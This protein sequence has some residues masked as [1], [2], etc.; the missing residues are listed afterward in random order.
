MDDQRLLR[1]GIIGTVVTAIC[2]FTPV[3]VVALGAV[4]LSAWLGWLDRVLL[5]LLALFIG[6]TAFG[7]Y[8]T[9]RARRP[10]GGVRCSRSR[11]PTS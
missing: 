10:D 4:G 2:C 8:R 5:P 7:L 9:R 3:L 11:P 6:L 1:T